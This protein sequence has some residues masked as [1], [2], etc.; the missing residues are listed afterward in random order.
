MNISAAKTPI[1]S[2]E[3]VK[4]TIIQDSISKYPGNCPCPYHSAKNGSRCGGRSAW[5]RA[6]GDAPICYDSDV[7]QEMIEKWRRQH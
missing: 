1:L 7:S 6:G 5:S 2:D 4:K 3:Q